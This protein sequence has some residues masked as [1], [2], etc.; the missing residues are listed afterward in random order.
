MACSFA[1]SGAR[2]GFAKCFLCS[3]VQG[4][5]SPPS[6]PDRLLLLTSS[7]GPRPSFSIRPNV[8][9]PAC[10]PQVLMLWPSVDSCPCGCGSA[11]AGSSSS[12]LGCQVRVQS[13]LWPELTGRLRDPPMGVSGCF[14]V[15]SLGSSAAPGH[16]CRGSGHHSPPVDYTLVPSLWTVEA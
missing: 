13:R 2:L 5:V 9:E 15:L 16:P 14:S 4:G 7:C 6:P 1:P 3:N 10:H 8:G 12:Q 11:S